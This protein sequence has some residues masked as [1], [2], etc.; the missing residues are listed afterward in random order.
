MTQRMLRSLFASLFL[1]G[2]FAAS[3]AAEE[4]PTE[5]NAPP[6]AASKEAAAPP[7]AEEVHAKQVITF[8]AADE[9]EGRGPGTAGINQAAE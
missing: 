8:L 2:S 1:F 5:K 3:F 9:R 7:S 4:K 6:A